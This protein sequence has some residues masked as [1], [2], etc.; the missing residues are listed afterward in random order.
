MSSEKCS[1][2]ENKEEIKQ[3]E[4]GKA[5]ATKEPE[6]FENIFDEKPLEVTR[7]NR[8]A[9]LLGALTGEKP[10]LIPVEDRLQTFNETQEKSLEVEKKP[11]S[12]ISPQNKVKHDK[13]VTFSVPEAADTETSSESSLPV[14]ND[15]FRP[16]MN[17]PSGSSTDTVTVNSISKITKISSESDS[18]L[19]VSSPI[20][21]A[22]TFSTSI[23]SSPIFSPSISDANLPLKPTANFS[24]GS[25]D[26]YGSSITITTTAAPVSMPVYTFTKPEESSSPNKPL[27]TSFS[28]PNTTTVPEIGGFKFNLPLGGMSKY[29]PSSSGLQIVSNSLTAVT[30]NNLIVSTSNSLFNKTVDTASPFPITTKSLF[31]STVPTSSAFSIA[32][33]SESNLTSYQFSANSKPP[34]FSLAMPSSTSFT[35]GITGTT[36]VSS[37]SHAIPSVT[38]F[39]N[40][41]TTSSTLMFGSATSEAFSFKTSSINATSSVAP[42][43]NSLITKNPALIKASDSQPQFNSSKPFSFINTTVADQTKNSLNTSVSKPSDGT[44]ASSIFT[45]PISSS[46]FGANTTTNI[47]GTPSFGVNATNNTSSAAKFQ[48][49]FSTSANIFGAN[50][51]TTS[52][53]KL[54]TVPTCTSMFQF[55]TPVTSNSNSAFGV[56][57]SATSTYQSPPKQP[58]FE[59]G[60]TVSNDSTV[61]FGSNTKNLNASNSFGTLP[62]NGF[63]SGSSTF[64][65]SNTLFGSNMSNNLSTHKSNVSKGFVAST[66]FGLAPNQTTQIKQ[67]GSSEFGAPFTGNVTAPVFNSNPASNAFQ[68]NDTQK[69]APGFGASATNSTFGKPQVTNNSF[70]TPPNSNFTSPVTAAASFGSATSNAFGMPGVNQSNPPA[71][72]FTPASQP[73]FTFGASSNVPVN[74][75]INKVFSFGA[76]EAAKSNDINFSAH[77]P[78]LGSGSAFG[79]NAAPTFGTNFAPQFN[80]PTAG[81]FSIGSGSN[82]PIRPRTH[83]KAKRRT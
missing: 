14:S 20:F 52:A 41:V 81:T 38:S 9:I 79:M 73:T 15:Y 23:A 27:N 64:G 78:G 40:A 16:T 51:A 3:T 1:A 37:M 34:V 31:S 26:H 39:G 63:G 59:I 44:T 83:L 80:A 69:L 68:L 66:P 25:V 30:S 2:N 56:A 47:G 75:P 19:K 77:T 18:P 82:A 61:A 21:S 62:G 50:T 22:S 67:E 48:N 4:S 35:S 17:I 58:A 13:H 60:K 65:A 33:K 54:S 57:S 55:G 70:M 42:T 71:F 5:E 28:T 43:F 74:P 10:Q 46:G 45:A 11:V 32:P 7:R 72:S 24:V 76:A 36:S 12:I 53:P 49:I 6:V 8:L 29:S